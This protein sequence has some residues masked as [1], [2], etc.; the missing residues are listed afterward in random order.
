METC[1]K[2]KHE[3][4]VYDPHTKS[5]RCLTMECQHNERMDYEHYSKEFEKEDKNVAHKLSFSRNH[6]TTPT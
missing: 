2:C 1:P 5:A 4:L 6:I 3:T